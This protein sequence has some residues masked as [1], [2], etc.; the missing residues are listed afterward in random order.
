MRVKLFAETTVTNQIDRI[1]EK[2]AKEKYKLEKKFAKKLEKF[3]KQAKTKIK[4]TKQNKN[5][6][7]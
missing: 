2:E 5:K 1:V 7:K 4:E 3:E 6:E